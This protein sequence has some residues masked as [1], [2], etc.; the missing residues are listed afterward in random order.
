MGV[1]PP[2]VV[3]VLRSNE[4]SPIRTPILSLILTCSGEKPVKPSSSVRVENTSNYRPVSQNKAV[5]HLAWWLAK[6][7]KPICF[8]SHSLSHRAPI[9]PARTP[10]GGL[11][12][13]DEGLKKRYF[14]GKSMTGGR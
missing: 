5:S 10:I 9:N 7:L 8:L 2:R 11:F 13:S 1:F 4:I 14:T 6:A 12:F 3:H